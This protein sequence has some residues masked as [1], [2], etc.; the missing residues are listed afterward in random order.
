[1]LAF[2]R[3]LRQ[4]G[5]IGPE[6]NRRD[7]YHVRDGSVLKPEPYLRYYEPDGREL[8]QTLSPF[9]SDDTES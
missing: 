7:F 2:P 1:M 6:G 9:C 5:H 8:E 4:A 3:A